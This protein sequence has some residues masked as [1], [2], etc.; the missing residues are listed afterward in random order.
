MEPQKKVIVG[1]SGGVDSAVAALLL[2]RQGYDVRGVFMKNWS[3]DDFGG[4]CPWQEDQ[5]S[6]T[7]VAEHLGIPLETWNF[8]REYRDLVFNSMLEEYKAGRTPNP[9]ILC[10]REIKF[11]LFFDRARETAD[12]V[13]TGHYA[14]TENGK[15]LKAVDTNKDQSYFLA[16]IT[17]A[18]LKYTLFP[19][20]EIE[21]SEVRTIAQEAGLPNW[22][23][24]DSVGICFIGE[25]QMTAWLGKHLELTPGPITLPDG[26]L[27]GQHRG[28]PLYTIGQRHGFGRDLD[29]ALITKTLGSVQSLFIKEKNLTTNTLV[30]APANEPEALLTKEFL[31]RDMHWISYACTFPWTGTAKFRYRQDDVKVSILPEGEKFRVICEEPQ[32]AITPGQYAVFYNNDVCLGCGVIE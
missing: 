17:S 32:R 24:K 1:I 3:E 28:F 29:Q 2:Q 8:E 23:R 13:A 9:D 31:V 15:L 22:D 10:N 27:V 14:R 18:A 20:G 19:L 7:A 26:T 25:K 16:G 6:A 5:T 30:V 4:P 21:K 12:L 11:K